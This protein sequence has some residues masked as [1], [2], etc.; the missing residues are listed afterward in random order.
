MK[1]Q[2]SKKFYKW[3]LRSLFRSGL[4][5]DRGTRS[6]NKQLLWTIYIWVMSYPPP[7][8]WPPC[9]IQNFTSWR[10]GET[11]ALVY[12]HAKTHT[13]TH[14]YCRRETLG[15]I[16]TT[17]PTFCKESLGIIFSTFPTFTT[18]PTF[19]QE[20]LGI[21]F[22]TFSTF[23]TSPTFCKESFG[24]QYFV[25]HVGGVEKVEE[26]GE[27]MPNGSLQK[28]GEVGKVVKMMPNGSLQNVGKHGKVGKVEKW[29]P[30]VLCK[31]LENLGRLENT[32]KNSPRHG[33]SYT[34]ERKPFPYQRNKPLT[35]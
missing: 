18:F 11:I 25:Q 2:C 4:V 17:F 6:Q 19:C 16:F 15:I 9:S 29:C 5:W 10:A 34:I 30:T 22:P 7:A 24:Y 28:V 1:W 32:R 3:V 21:I 13:I 23:P 31:M 12:N 35:I 26:V 20:S 8:F 14:A 27:M 33:S